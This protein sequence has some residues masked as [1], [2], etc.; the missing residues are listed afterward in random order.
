MDKSR[1]KPLPFHHLETGA[2]Y[3]RPRQHLPE[4]VTEDDP[5]IDCM[6]DL[7][8]VTAILVSLTTPLHMA[9]ERMVK[10]GVR[11]LLVADPDGTVRGLITSRDIQ[12]EKPM[13][14]LEKTGGR[15]EDLLVRDIM[16]LHGKL[17]VL[18]MEDVLR[19]KVGDII[20]TL[21]EVDRQHAMVVDTD[22]DTGKLAIRGIFSLSQIAQ[23]LGLPIDPS[24]RATT[25]AELEQALTHPNV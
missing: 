5:A 15:Y 17:E 11:L 6:T 24:Q 25:F 3:F 19:A 23:Q 14:I 13:K 16:T 21:K 4:R 2:T 1:Y 18:R 8:Q 9:H 12:G 10:G 20:A 7:R 22:P